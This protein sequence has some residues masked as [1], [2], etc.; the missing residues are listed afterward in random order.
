MKHIEIKLKEHIKEPFET[1]DVQ[2]YMFS[3]RKDKI[4][5]DANIFPETNLIVFKPIFTIYNLQKSMGT[6]VQATI[7]KEMSFNSLTDKHHILD[8]DFVSKEL[9]PTYEPISPEASN[10]AWIHPYTI[11]DV[12]NC[13]I[14]LDVRVPPGVSRLAKVADENYGKMTHCRNNYLVHTVG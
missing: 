14:G 5:E 8:M 2:V 10:M 1:T 13:P 11:P 6:L 12:S 4:Q 3:L 7:V 9:V